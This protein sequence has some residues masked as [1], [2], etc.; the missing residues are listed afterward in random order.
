VLRTA[1]ARI[2]ARQGG[3]G[4][5]TAREV[6]VLVLL[7]RGNSNRQIARKLVVAPKTASNHV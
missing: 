4:G 6:E 3:P 5:L 2:P 7:A 1:G